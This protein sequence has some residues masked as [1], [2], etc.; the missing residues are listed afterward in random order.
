MENEETIHT[1]YD[2]LNCVNALRGTD[3]EMAIAKIKKALELL[4]EKNIT[5]IG[6]QKELTKR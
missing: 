4:G 3:K 6:N 2:A 5:W 1:L